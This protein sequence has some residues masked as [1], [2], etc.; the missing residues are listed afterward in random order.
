MSKVRETETSFN[1][2]SIT[3]N[4]LTKIKIANGAIGGQSKKL[5]EIV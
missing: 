1:V 4:K 2:K 5:E 3:T